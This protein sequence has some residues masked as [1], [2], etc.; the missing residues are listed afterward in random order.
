METP[1]LIHSS[2]AL[3]DMRHYYE[4]QDLVLKVHIPIYQGTTSYTPLA[5]NSH[6]KSVR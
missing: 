3:H 1:I 6:A 2:L 4:R 5:K